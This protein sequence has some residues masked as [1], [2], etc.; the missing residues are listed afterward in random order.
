MLIQLNI[1]GMTLDARLR[2][3]VHV[4]KKRQELDI[5][6][7]KMYWLLGRKFK[8]LLYNQILRLMVSST[9]VEPIRAIFK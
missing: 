6:L 7:K 5:K 9:G 4:K 2:W 1:W 3:K 8:L